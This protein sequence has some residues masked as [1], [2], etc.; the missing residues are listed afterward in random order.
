MIWGKSTTKYLWM[1]WYKIYT[2]YF[3][4]KVVDYFSINLVNSHAKSLYGYLKEHTST[5]V[6]LASL[7]R[8]V[9][10]L[11]RSS[12]PSL[13]ASRNSSYSKF[14]NVKVGSY[15][16]NILLNI[17]GAK[18]ISDFPYIWITLISMSNLS[19]HH[20][21]YYLKLATSGMHPDNAILE[22]QI[23]INFFSLCGRV[24]YH[25]KA[26]NHLN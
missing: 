13:L 25:L 20:R 2:I 22:V 26:S 12:I 24:E 6:A 15:S 5:C 14:L 1:K 11:S 4:T 17:E 19:A 7:V 10:N 18:E 8:L 3:G 9:R 23:L 21:N 16:L